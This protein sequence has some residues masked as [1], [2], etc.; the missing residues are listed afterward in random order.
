M[1]RKDER[2]LYKVRKLNKKIA[3][4]ELK[5]DFILNERKLYL[6]KK[7]INQNKE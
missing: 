3:M 7:G 5:I 2:M 1:F 6:E 4:I